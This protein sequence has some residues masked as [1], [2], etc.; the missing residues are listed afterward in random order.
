[1]GSIMLATAG[2]MAELAFICADFIKTG[3]QPTVSVLFDEI[4]AT[5]GAAFEI[6]SNSFVSDPPKLYGPVALP[7]TI[8]SNR[9]YFGQ[10]TPENSQIGDVPLPAWAKHIQVKVDFGDTDEVQNEMLAFTIFGAL[11]QER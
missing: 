3:S 10:T 11:Y 5:N 9:Y 2:Q 6:I 7:A 1:M 8:W 4:S